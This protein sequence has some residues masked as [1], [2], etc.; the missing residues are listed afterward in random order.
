MSIE[1]NLA[2]VFDENEKEQFK[3]FLKQFNE[4]EDFEVLVKKIIL[5]SLSE[6]KE[7]FL[8]MGMPSRADEILQYRLNF[9]IKF[10]YEDNI[11]SEND[12]SMMFHLT[13]N[14]SKGLLRSLMVRFYHENNRKLDKTLFKILDNANK[15]DKKF[16]I[17]IPSKFFLEELNSRI[18]KINPKLQIITKTKG[19]SALYE[20]D[21]KTLNKLKEDLE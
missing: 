18:N 2:E 4:D 13:Q 21:E 12:V 19:T 10:F 6:Y 20:I 16:T 3:K 7:M 14:K 9:L 5:A 1:V 8:G 15:D 17:I 11:P